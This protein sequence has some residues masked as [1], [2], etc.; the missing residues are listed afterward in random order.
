MQLIRKFQFKYLQAKYSARFITNRSKTV[1]INGVFRPHGLSLMS[2][3]WG[4]DLNMVL[5]GLISG[6]ET[7]P[8]NLVFPYVRKYIDVDYMCIGSI[9]N[10]QTTK[11]SVIWGSG[12]ISDQLPI[13]N[14]PYKVLAV[15][16]P[17][18]RQFLIKNGVKCPA[19]YGDP[20]LLL[21]RFYSPS[22][23]IKYRLGIIPHVSERY[24]PVVKGIG[25]SLNSIIIDMGNY[26]SDWKSVIDKIA[27]C[28]II[29]SSSLHGLVCAEAYGIPNVWITLS[30]KIIGGEFKFKDFFM[31]L[32]KDR[33]ALLLN[34]N[35]ADSVQRIESEVAKWS[36]PSHNLD[37]ALLETCPFL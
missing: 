9:I 6:K 30:N 34:D 8:Y 12:A 23:E 15:R 28:E 5:P 21:P 4:D 18:S 10:W 3:I 36:K 13:A 14:K 31:S 17:L 20:A 37:E 32:D 11:R 1:V 35:I 29:A 27:A 26:E 7:I 16:G 25:N 33:E 19:R 22:R 2:E 24:L